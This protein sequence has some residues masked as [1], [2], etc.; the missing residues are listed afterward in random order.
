[1]SLAVV[2]LLLMKHLMTAARQRVLRK[3]KTMKNG[4]EIYFD[5]DTLYVVTPEG[6]TGSMR[7]E[8]F[9]D[10]VRAPAVDL[11]RVIPPKGVIQRVEGNAVIWIYQRDPQPYNFKWIAPDSATPFGKGTKYREV[12]IALPYLVV[13]AVF[14]VVPPGRL[15][16]TISNEA[17]FSNAAI[18]SPDDPLCFPALLNCSMFNPPDGRPL[19]WICTQHLDRS[20][21]REDDLN[22]RMNGGLKALLKCLL[23]AGFNYSSEKHEGLS[24]FTASQK[25]DDRISTVEKWEAASKRSQLFALEVPWLPTGFTV[26]GVTERIFKRLNATRPPLKTAADVARIVFNQ[27]PKQAPMPFPFEFFL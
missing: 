7:L 22:R 12:S 15:T 26:A 2:P 3:R 14:S 6:K 11:S 10:K 16:L 23:E 24:G 27:K 8:E 13:F 18:R 25:L 21:D 20:F 1:M 17:F 9:F 19:A 4:Y 5:S